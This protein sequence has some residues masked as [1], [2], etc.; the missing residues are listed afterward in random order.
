MVHAQG[1]SQDVP[2]VA[3]DVLVSSLEQSCEAGSSFAGVQ[4]K[5][6]L[7][8]SGGEKGIG[9]SPPSSPLHQ[10]ISDQLGSPSLRPHHFRSLILGEGALYQLARDE[11]SSAHSKCLSVQD[12]RS[13]SGLL[14]EAR[15][16]DFLGNVQFASRYC[17]L[18]GT[19]FSDFDC[20]MYLD[21]EEHPRGSV[22]LSTPDHSH[23]VALHFPGVRS[24]LQSFRCV[25]P[26]PDPKAWK[27]EAF[28]CS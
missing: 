6:W 23:Q 17:S 7:L 14:K 24:H 16:Y 25:S 10:C 19:V 21:E 11:G 1:S 26:V 8:A 5:H 4:G 9:N 12:H 13:V 18:V 2:S 28:Q 15:V 20:K 3:A 22:D 27:Q